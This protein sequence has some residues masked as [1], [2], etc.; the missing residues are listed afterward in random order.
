MADFLKDGMGIITEMGFYDLASKIVK[1]MY[2]ESLS[3]K[4]EVANSKLQNSTNTNNKI[5][6]NKV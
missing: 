1:K 2:K 5:T 6:V 4:S 3:L